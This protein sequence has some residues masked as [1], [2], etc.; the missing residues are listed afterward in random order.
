M[1]TLRRWWAAAQRTRLYGAWKRYGDSRGSVLA[2]GVGYFAF[3]SI[4]PAVLLA[5]TVFGLVLRDQPQLLEEAKNAVNDL[6]PGFVKSQ[7]NP[8]GVIDVTAPTRAALT[9]SGVLSV[10]GLVFAGVGWL[11]AMRDAIRAIFGVPGPT[12]N[13][14]VVKARD[15]GVMLVLGLGIVLSGVV[16]AV[17]GA[18]SAWVAGH[19]GLGGQGW[20][21]TASSVVLGVV[22]DA[23]LVGFLVRVESGVEV[24][25][26]VL[27][28]AALIGGVGLTA[29]KKFGTVLLS[30]TLHN[31][32][33]ASFALVVGLLLWLNLMSRVILVAAAWAANDLD[34]STGTGTLSPGQREKLLEG[35]APVPATARDR[36][37]EGLPVLGQ[38]AT[39]RTAML[40]GA[41]LGAVGAAMLGAVLRGIRGLARR[42]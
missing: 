38:P 11:G 20:V 8:N 41:V 3:F 5:F 10:V 32:L 23:V 33:Y 12:A 39:A 29:L 21:L 25:W 36:L 30:G 26:R 34:L 31:P 9:V 35:P 37:Q 1:T 42:E 2:G 19:V 28:T 27:R 15:L 17:T 13:A 6:V 7:D 16:G 40:A 22:L 4:F 18:V 14:V 24:P